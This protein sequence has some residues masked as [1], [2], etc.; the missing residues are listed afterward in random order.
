M[1]KDIQ[2]AID[3]CRKDSQL[4]NLGVIIIVSVSNAIVALLMRI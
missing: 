2:N 4:N 3:F 1:R